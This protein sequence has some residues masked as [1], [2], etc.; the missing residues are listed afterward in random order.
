MARMSELCYWFC[1]GQRVNKKATA[2]EGRNNTQEIKG[3]GIKLSS[4]NGSQEFLEHRVPGSPSPS[5][6]STST[7]GRHRQ[8]SPRTRSVKTWKMATNNDE[9][10][11]RALNER[12]V[13]GLF[14]LSEPSRTFFPRTKLNGLLRK[15]EVEATL[16]RAR[17]HPSPELVDFI[18]TKADKIF[19]ILAA[20][21]KTDRIEAFHKG[22]FGQNRLPAKQESVGDMFFSPL[23]VVDFCRLQ[24]WFMSPVFTEDTFRYN[25]EKSCQLPFTRYGEKMPS[26]ASNYSSVEER[27]IHVGHVQLRPDQKLV[28]DERGHPRVALK[29]LN[30]TD[31]NLA[32]REASALEMMRELK[33]DHLIKAIA[34]F[35]QGDKHSFIFPWAEHG[36]LWDFLTAEDTRDDINDNKPFFIWA[37]K[38]L[39]ALAMA[40]E[41]LH[42]QFCR[43]G[44]LKPENILCFREDDR[45]TD[46]PAPAVR[47]VITDV[48]L[49]KSH[50]KATEFRR[51]KTQT[52]VSTKRYAAPEMEVDPNGKLSRR[53]DI[54]A[55]GCIFLECVIWILYGPKELERCTIY[56]KDTFYKTITDSNET[57]T[58]ELHPKVQKWVSYI[59]KDWRCSKGTALRRLVDLIVNKLLIVKVQDSATS[60]PVPGVK[61]HATWTQNPTQDTE[62]LGQLKYRT[63]AAGM[64][65]ALVGI[66][67]DLESDTIDAIGKRPFENTPDPKGPC[68]SLSSTFNGMLAVPH[69]QFTRV[70]QAVFDT[71]SS[72]ILTTHP[73]QQ[74]TSSLFP[75]PLSDNWNYTPDDSFP[76]AFFADFEL[77]LPV[78]Q[79]YEAQLCRRCRGLSLWSVE[80]NFMDSRHS[81]DAK[82]FGGH[83]CSLCQL[84]SHCIRDRLHSPHEIVRFARVGSYLTVDDGQ[85]QPVIILST[86]P[87]LPGPQIKPSPNIQTSFSKLPD[88]G[89]E[90]HLK[91]LREWIRSCDSTHECL[92]QRL[93]FVPRRLLDIGDS[94]SD[95]VRLLE[96]S[97]SLRKPKKYAA[98]SHRWGSPQQH[99]KF[100]ALKSNI[101]T[102]MRGFEVS[103]LPKTFRDAVH[104]ARGL[105]LDYLWIDSICIVQD[106]SSDWDA[107]SKLMEQV[108]SSAYCTIA[109][110]CA[111]GTSDGFLKSRPERRCIPMKLGD[112]TYY[113]CEAIDDFHSH[114]DQSELNQRGWVM[115]ERAL[116]RRTIYF[117]ELQSYWECGGG[118]RC[119][120]MTKMK[121]RKASFLGD[122]N[123]PHSADKYVKGMKIEFFQDLYERFSK[124]ALSRVSDRPVAIKGVEARLLDT[125]HTSGGYGIFDIYLYRSLLWQRGCE[126]LSRIP[127]TRGNPVPSW[128]WMA[129]DGGIRYLPVPFG[130][131]AWQDDIKSPFSGTSDERQGDGDGQAPELE[132][133]VWDI[134]DEPA[135]ESLIFDEP[136]RELTRPL[137]CIV[138][139]NNK[140]E[141]AND[142]QTHWVIL[143]HCISSTSNNSDGH[144]YERLGVGVLERRHIDCR[145]TAKKGKIR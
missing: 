75:Q 114:V 97:L 17:V 24:W 58:A 94:K 22:K 31:R 131:A 25:F 89:G 141:P 93:D 77:V 136:L 18:M 90:T 68:D 16:R 20:M 45:A 44:D 127:T 126:S 29:E 116:S 120:T 10:L 7:P 84:L 132:A 142:S 91:V 37:F 47:M 64:R 129:Y 6:E 134:I 35:Q 27:S 39:T 9:T 122:A 124:L 36:N 140:T 130:K 76:P 111:S 41:E 138:V 73:L 62:S 106:D 72:P 98:L 71:Q 133:P 2:A 21:D 34:Y 15:A 30:F 32:E 8:T 57:K 104:I 69:R 110:S 55:I 143:V 63:Y 109:A 3:D 52:T 26:G 112:E 119:E 66:L 4:D 33:S 108:F 78:P 121:N 54:W 61:T 102:L 13:E 113:A 103:L 11:V 28:M 125:F 117:T 46:N 128:S 100:C 92:P 99:A 101:E 115:Q 135:A 107:E 87:A 145:G 81:L 56:L 49:A 38:Q 65:Q 67:E 23:A 95:M 53:F 50:D 86:M 79:T 123:F 85:E 139:G 12:V 118:V 59:K 40:I 88:A 96:I 19:A 137:T 60:S 51:D 105:K 43:H 1:I 83:G 5:S 14:Y 70:R 42:S 74:N 144:V 80:C 82:G 48:G